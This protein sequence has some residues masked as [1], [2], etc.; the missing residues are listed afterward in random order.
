MT[1]SADKINQYCAQINE[2]LGNISGSDK[3]IGLGT[4]MLILVLIITPGRM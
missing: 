2:T 1:N 4:L 3:I